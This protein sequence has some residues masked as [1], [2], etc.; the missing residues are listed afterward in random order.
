MD[1]GGS[2]Y[3]RRRMTW[4]CTTSSRGG[5]DWIWS[6]REGGDLVIMA[7]LTKERDEKV[8]ARKEKGSKE[9]QLEL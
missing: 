8:R 1:L 4:T 9:D 3:H 6:R 2:R 5:G 7:L